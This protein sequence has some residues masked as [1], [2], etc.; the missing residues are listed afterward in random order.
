MPTSSLHLSSRAPHL[1]AVFALVVGGAIV[2]FAQ[3]ADRALP[4]VHTPSSVVGPVA[5][6]SVPVE[7]A[8]AASAPAA[9]PLPVATP[10]GAAD[11]VSADVVADVPA[12][13]ADPFAAVIVEPV[14]PAEALFGDSA[15]VAAS[16]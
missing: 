1:A 15:A 9:T 11:D 12:A 16:N 13:E 7:S 4:N 6:P 2:W 5:M 8:E 10:V 3:G 14:D